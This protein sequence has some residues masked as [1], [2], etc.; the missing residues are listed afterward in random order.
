MYNPEVVKVCHSGRDLRKLNVPDK[1][2]E[3]CER[4][5][6]GLTNFKRFAAGLDIVYCMMFPLCIHSVKMWKRCDLA[7]METPSRGET[8]GWD[9]CFQAIISRHNRWDTTE[10]W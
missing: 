1:Q 6:R 5:G 9:K 7:E 10:Q 4:M 8:F 3:N 2:E